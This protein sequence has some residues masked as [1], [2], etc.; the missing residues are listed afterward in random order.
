MASTKYLWIDNSTSPSSGWREKALGRKH[1]ETRRLL[2]YSSTLLGELAA[3]TWPA[4]THSKPQNTQPPPALPSRPSPSIRQTWGQVG[5]MDCDGGDPIRPSVRGGIATT[6]GEKKKSQQSHKRVE[7]HGFRA[8]DCNLRWPVG[9]ISICSN[10][11]S[12]LE[13]E[14]KKGNM[15]RKIK[16][17][18]KERGNNGLVCALPAPNSAHRSGRARAHSPFAGRY[19][20]HMT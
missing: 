20:R 1:G 18:K 13:K 3:G 2:H 12:L 10:T 14:E 7:Y 4:R 15:A 16:G 9:T 17:T 6:S 19:D 11:I 5:S 8:A